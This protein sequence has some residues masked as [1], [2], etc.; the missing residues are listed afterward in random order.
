LSKLELS[1]VEQLA[2]D[3]STFAD[4][5]AGAPTVVEGDKEESVLLSRNGFPTELKVS[6]V[7][8]SIEEAFA[9]RTIRHA[10]FKALLASERYGALRTWADHQKAFLAQ[11]PSEGSLI[12][13]TGT[14]N[15]GIERC[16]LAGV[17]AVLVSA[18]RPN[19]TRVVLIDG[20]AG[21]GKTQFI[22]SMSKSRA[23][24]Y[25]SKQSPLVLHIQSRGRTL[26]YLSDL[27]AFSL[28]RLRVDVTFDQ[29]PTLV[30]YG[31]ITIAVDGFDELADPEGYG[32][33]W[34]QVSE[35]VESVRG[36][37]SIILAGR[38]TFIGRE[39]LLRDV[40]TLRSDLD[41]ISVFTLDAP[42]KS[43]AL[44]FLEVEGWSA[45]QLEAI[46]NFLEPS[47]LALRPF[48]LRTLSD[49]AI[50][51]S[52]GDAS[53]SSILAILVEAMIDRE[54][55]KSH[56]IGKFGE[57]VEFELNKDELR[58]YVR[59]L[60]AEIA[61]DMAD[62]STVA[63][64]DAT[65]SFLVDVALPKS[66]TDGV[67]RI[68][69]TRVQSVAFLTNDD[70]PGYRRFQHEKFYEYFL[71]VVII[72]S[73]STE[74]AIK[75]IA[76]NLL[77]SSFLET[78]GGIIAGSASV[79]TARRF[80]VG[81]IAMARSYA[82]LDRTRRNLGALLIASLSIADLVPEFAIE[83][84]ETD[85]VRFSGTAAAASLTRVVISQFD[86]RG[87]D[88][89]EVLFENC[90]VISLIGDESTLLPATF[91]MPTRIQDV[92]SSADI[93]NPMEVEQWITS[94]LRNPPVRSSK[95]VPDNLRDHEAIRL[96]QR[97]CRLKQ[98]WMRRGDDT[99]SNRILDDAYWPTL[100]R[101]LSDNDLLRVE[102]RPAAGRDAR[103]VHIK[104]ADQILAEY[105][106]NPNVVGLYRDL[107]SELQ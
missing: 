106:D 105:R 91:P 37:G 100:E 89:S 52:L 2:M 85:E 53:S 40:K 81:A 46:E 47:S 14:M 6:L 42:T 7:N 84:V 20:P 76:R 60:M 69:K 50:A 73:I 101:I 66:V 43:E 13:I 94:H 39:R 36:Q 27:M 74:Q 55:G 19:S 88:L 1:V 96:L 33:A 79:E 72:D 93:T 95:L 26:S 44:R 35:L 71:S 17:E 16:D 59:S 64:S 22:L 83:N 86:C 77:A 41:D 34:S 104:W 70:R 68:L 25:A 82:A 67:S 80:L 57:A 29:V 31:L 107:V 58:K 56:E 78:F 75:P 98:Y 8:E 21:I 32:M 65:L 62:N 92:A 30:K 102:S 61:R 63:V 90:V 9:D 97:A 18:R 28:Q 10:S 48:F 103:F 38:E 87:A 23:D 5:G 11:E 99:Y 45:P 15:N 3:L 24:A 12:P 54:I 49:S 51:S 4:L